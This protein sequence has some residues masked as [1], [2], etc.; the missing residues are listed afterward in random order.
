VRFPRLRS[1]ELLHDLTSP[2]ASTAT[3]RPSP[4]EQPIAGERGQ[5]CARCQDADE[6]QRSA[7][8]ATAT[9]HHVPCGR[10][11][12]SSPTASAS[13]TARRRIRRRSGHRESRRAPRGAGKSGKR[14]RHGGSQAAHARAC[15]RRVLPQRRRSVRNH[16]LHCIAIRI[17]RTRAASSSG[18]RPA[19][20]RPA[21]GV[22]HPN[23]VMRRRR[24]AP[25]EDFLRSAG[26]RR[27]RN[28]PKLSEFTTPSATSS[29]S[30]AST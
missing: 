4:I 28:P 7:P 18:A 20:E 10:M 12:R 21:P 14:S 3:G 26:T 22:R 25:D 5:P 30:A 29:A 27:A 2:P 8:T 16:V 23:S 19:H 17:F 15:S 11:S 9:C 13:H 1:I 6:V 24:G